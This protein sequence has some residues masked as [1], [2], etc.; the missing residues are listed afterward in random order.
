MKK[1]YCIPEAKLLWLG[2]QDILTDSGN[3]TNQPDYPDNPGGGG[4]TDGSSQV[5]DDFWNEP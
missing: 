4:G 5:G 1:L 3:W 2:A